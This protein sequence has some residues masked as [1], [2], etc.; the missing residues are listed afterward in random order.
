MGLFSS[1]LGGGSA[2]KGPSDAQLSRR[3]AAAAVEETQR[4]I[5]EARKLYSR[6]SKVLEDGVSAAPDVS[7]GSDQDAVARAQGGIAGAGGLQEFETVPAPPEAV[8]VKPGDPGFD[9]LN[10]DWSSHD[11]SDTNWFTNR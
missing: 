6:E 9:Y 8:A 3:A 2:S 4:Q 11:W 10:Y 5:D 1:I 7:F